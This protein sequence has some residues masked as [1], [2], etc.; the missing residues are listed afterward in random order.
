MH[1]PS[2]TGN[3]FAMEA[4]L[5]EPLEHM[6]ARVSELMIKASAVAE[7]KRLLPGV[8]HGSTK[9]RLALIDDFVLRGQGF[10]H[11]LSTD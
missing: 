11:R 3:S 9:K 1:V 5:F 10:L 2:R 4:R 8:N 6:V 7:R